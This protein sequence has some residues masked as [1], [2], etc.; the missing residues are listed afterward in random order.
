MTVRKP[1]FRALRQRLQES[2]QT[3]TGTDLDVAWQYND[4]IR[5]PALVVLGIGLAHS[6]PP[7]CLLQASLCPPKF[8]QKCN[9]ESKLELKGMAASN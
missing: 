9:D 8:S 7:L 2:Y 5:I 6:L 1:P 4:R 3:Y